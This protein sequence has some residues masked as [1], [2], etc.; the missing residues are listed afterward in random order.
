MNVGIVIISIALSAITEPELGRERSCL[1][2]FGATATAQHL[3]DLPDDVR[4]GLAY[5]EANVARS[6]IA[7]RGAPILQTDVVSE[8]ERYLP[9]ARFTEAIQVGDWWF[10]QIEVSM[11]RGVRTISFLRHSDGR[12]RLSPAHHFQGPPCA[13]IRAALDGVTTPGGF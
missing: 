6:T 4:S 13:S 8:N 11:V 1:Q 10:V 12:F 2:E 5:F 3:A 7:E 9:Q